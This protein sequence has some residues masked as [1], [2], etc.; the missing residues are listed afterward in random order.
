MGK[1][2]DMVDQCGSWRRTGVKMWNIACGTHWDNRW[3]KEKSQK[4]ELDKRYNK[5]GRS[6]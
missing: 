3:I 5:Q 4:D 2:D 6:D 1:N